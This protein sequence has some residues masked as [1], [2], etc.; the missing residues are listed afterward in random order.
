MSQNDSNDVIY[1]V[2][3]LSGICVLGLIVN[4]V[5]NNTTFIAMCIIFSGMLGLLLVQFDLSIRGQ[6]SSNKS[7]IGV[8]KKLFHFRNLIFMLLLT[9]WV[10]D[11]YLNN[12]NDIG[13]NKMPPTFYS[14][15]NAY[16]WVIV[17][18]VIMV[19]GNFISKK[20]QLNNEIKNDSSDV[21]SKMSKLYNAQ[22][23]S[24]NA[25]LN[26]VNLIMVII[27]YVISEMFVT[28]G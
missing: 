6:M 24:L 26:V 9:G 8:I 4:I 1:F 13:K 3:V 25:I 20:K 17:C 10:F 2:K 15:S 14:V 23:S 19:A 7:F 21:F 5:F 16:M 27:L 22:Y 11:I 12:Y 18:Q 28:D